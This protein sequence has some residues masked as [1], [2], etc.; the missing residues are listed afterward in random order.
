M[1]PPSI[2]E[3][4]YERERPSY[5][6]Y[7]TLTDA[8]I[9]ERKRR[10]PVR[11]PLW[12][13]LRREQKICFL[14]GV[15]R[16][17]FAFFLDTGCGKTLLSIAIV[18]YLR[19][20]KKVRRALVLVPNILNGDEWAAEI[21]KH[22]GGR[23]YVILTGSSA[24]KWTQLTQSN[25]LFVVTTYAGFL[26]M[27]CS[28]D[29]EKLRLDA[30][31]L[32]QI[33]EQVDAL[34]LDESTYVQSRSSLIH[35]ACL[36]IARK[37]TFRYLLTGTP[38]GRDP[39]PIWAQAYLVDFGAT[40]GQTIGLFRAYF[41]TE[42]QGFFRTE[43]VPDPSKRA[44]LHRLLSSFSIRYKAS[45]ADLPK[46]VCIRKE[47]KLA[48]DA[49]DLAVASL[50]GL[51]AEVSQERQNAFLRSRQISSGFMG[52]T[53]QEGAKVKYDFS[54]NPKLELL[55][56]TVKTIPV[57]NKIVVFHEFIHSGHRLFSALTKAG[58]KALH[59]HDSVKDKG[60]LRER[61]ESDPDCQVLILNNNAGAMGLNL[62]FAK[63][64]MVYESPVRYVVRRQMIGRVHRQRSRHKTVFLIDFVTKA[65]A[66][67]R[68]LDLY[69]EGVDAA[70]AV[71]D[72]A[73]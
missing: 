45:E 51:R 61:F 67:G 43:Y 53:D 24:H 25:S 38:M 18:S 33:V 21:R 39:T 27:V 71:V 37:V 17:A 63:Y 68:I 56:E 72:G 57:R 1:I 12:R 62:Q 20:A 46:L 26:R 32:R 14:L 31:K 5:R 9:E 58:V 11:P 64:L 54:V 4:F 13:L 23:D 28:G 19:K 49:V 52:Y 70:T 16:K 3:E 2:V 30:A 44:T 50:K 36:R 15:R 6:W 60:A 8:E 55:V 34:V 42:K 40:L 22:T 59:I 48:P 35:R 65:T 7:K 66:D 29:G 47:V 69:E 41:F 10:L 73:F